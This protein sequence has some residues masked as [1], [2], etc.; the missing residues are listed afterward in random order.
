MPRLARCSELSSKPSAAAT[1]TVGR[2][3]CTATSIS[4]R[5]GIR[6]VGRGRHRTAD[7]RLLPH[8]AQGC[9]DPAAALFE[10]E[11]V[12]RIP[13]AEVGISTPARRRV[14]L[15]PTPAGTHVQSRVARTQA[16]APAAVVPDLATSGG[17]H[18]AP[19]GT[20]P[21][22]SHTDRHYLP[23]ETRPC[24]QRLR[25]VEP[26]SKSVT[27]PPLSGQGGEVSATAGVIGPGPRRVPFRRH[28]LS[29]V[30]LIHAAPR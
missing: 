17:L 2:S 7:L 27:P 30:T 5:D 28:W 15:T 13:G 4:A 26:E 10:L 20:T 1:G 14:T 18:A 21:A 9:G 29:V 16:A 8:P 19:C 11:R 23:R 25:S 3:S 24:L 22:A 6:A 12:Q